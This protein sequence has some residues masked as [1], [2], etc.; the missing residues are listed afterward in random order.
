[1]V[2]DLTAEFVVAIIQTLHIYEECIRGK[3]L[4]EKI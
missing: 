2:A 1:M 4:G 3:D